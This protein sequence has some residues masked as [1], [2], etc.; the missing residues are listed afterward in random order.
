MSPLHLSRTASV[1]GSLALAAL[2][3]ACADTAVAPSH[4]S[5]GDA[6]DSENVYI[7]A[8]ADI[9]LNGHLFG[10]DN[11]T[12]V[13]LTHMRP[14]D[15]SAWFE[16]AEEL[17]DNGF[18]ALTFDF[19]GFGESDGDEDFDEL[20]DDL[21]V[22]MEYMRARGWTD[23]L[24]VGASMGGT[25]ALVVAAEESVLG[26]VSVSS[27]AEF[28]AQNALAAAPA[29]TAP[30]LFIAAEE[31]TAAVLSLDELVAAA[32]QP[33]ESQLYPGNDHGTN[34]LAGESADA[35]RT[36]VLNFLREHRGN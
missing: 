8:E 9:I 16:F 21:R 15:Q 18:A 36:L 20:D 19:R 33:K 27:P 12:L 2:A 28:E 5:N 24:L 26:V 22:V 34:L 14:N 29:I 23:I 32:G 4:E 1:L 30:K 10:R 13:V 11:D 25:A 17:A 6:G 31:D 7:V 3:A 35:F